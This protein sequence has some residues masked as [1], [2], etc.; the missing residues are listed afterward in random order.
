MMLRAIA[1]WL[2]VMAVTIA[3]LFGMVTIEQ[4]QHEAEPAAPPARPG[5]RIQV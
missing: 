1:F 3:G 5:P 4:Q 2:F